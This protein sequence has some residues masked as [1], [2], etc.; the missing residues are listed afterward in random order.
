MDGAPA[1]AT[2]LHKSPVALRV[3]RA[4]AG[5]PGG[6][7]LLAELS[8]RRGLDDFNALGA[9]ELEKTGRRP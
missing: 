4:G 3:A 7:A 6:D 1:D 5:L 2:P 8:D 9:V